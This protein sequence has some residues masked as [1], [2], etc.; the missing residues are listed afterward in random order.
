MDGHEKQARLRLNAQGEIE[1]DDG[2]VPKPKKGAK[3]K[4]AGFQTLGLSK[5]IYGGVMRM[6]YKVP[7]PI[8]RK[9]LPVALTGADVVAM[10]RTGS[11]KTA[12][13]LIP[14]L[15]KLKTHSAVGIRAIILSPTRELAIQTMKFARG[16]G[17]F[18]DLR[19]CLLVGGDGLEQQVFF[20]LF[21]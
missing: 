10:A 6:G 1:V 5:P 19:I 4:A 15:E 11:G 12:A 14:M 17:K 2:S 18:T 7:T 21:G 3:K 20:I 8:Q 13:F 9:A 16:L